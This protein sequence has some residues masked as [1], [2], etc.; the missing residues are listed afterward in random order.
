MR[1]IL[2]IDIMGGKC[3]RLTKGDFNTKKIYNDDPLEVAKEIEAH[4]VKYLH[5]VDLDGAKNRRM[6]NLAVLERLASGTGMRIDYGGGLRTTDDLRRVFDAGAVQ[7]TGGSIA[8]KDRPMFLSWLA[9][10]GPSKII[11][12]ADGKGGRIS[13]AGWV[14]NTD[15]DLVGFIS[16]YQ[17]LGVEYTVCTDI[18]KDGMLQGPSTELYREILSKVK[19]NLIASG[20]VS[21]VKDIRDLE[22]AGCEGAIIGKAIYEGRITLNE[23][24]R[25]CL[26]GE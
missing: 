18:D 26:K 14:E 21:S 3:V 7:V 12:G 9:E 20:G 11:L 23:I 6:E 24:E 16:D 1:L 5:L 10:F 19:I 15:Q 17:K 4:G 22:E 8:V 13:A 2:A 25:L